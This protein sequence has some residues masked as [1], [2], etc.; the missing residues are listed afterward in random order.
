MKC[1]FCNSALYHTYFKVLYE[2]KEIIICFDCYSYTDKE[3][4]FKSV[5]N[6][7]VKIH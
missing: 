5:L 6:D 7:K 3:I 2:K 1:E 4:K